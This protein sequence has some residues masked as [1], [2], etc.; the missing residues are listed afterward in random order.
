MID[1]KQCLFNAIFSTQREIAV[2]CWLPPL[3]QW[4]S[5]PQINLAVPT[6]S[7]FHPERVPVGTARP[8]YCS[9]DYSNSNPAD[10]LGNTGSQQGTCTSGWVVSKLSGTLVSHVSMVHSRMWKWHF[11]KAE[12]KEEQSLLGM[13]SKDHET[14]NRHQPTYESY[15]LTS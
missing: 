4:R 7:E 5:P 10:A 13:L 14:I 6:G 1:D 15:S 11:Q 2:I 3:A 9:A 12:R 8:G